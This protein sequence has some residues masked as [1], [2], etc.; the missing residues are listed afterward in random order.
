M[1]LPK[2]QPVSNR[3]E[4]GC[5]RLLDKRRGLVVDN[6]EKIF[7]LV[8]NTG[9]EIA[10]GSR[11]GSI[12]VSRSPAMLPALRS[13]PSALLIA[14]LPKTAHRAPDSG[15]AAPEP[16]V[17]LLRLFDKGR[18][19]GDAGCA[20]SF[21]RLP[22]PRRSRRPVAGH[23]STERRV[24]ALRTGAV[25]QSNSSAS[26]PDQA[27]SAVRRRMLFSTGA[28]SPQAQGRQRLLRSRQSLA[29]TVSSR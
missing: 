19:R 9:L 29:K 16:F 25:T 5:R 28:P 3:V 15:A 1:T 13:E 26:R 10:S 18:D 8:G 23:I 22:S 12:R 24:Q 27:A 21:R 4:E 2:P 20:A 11:P 14:R 17:R 7:A 6:P